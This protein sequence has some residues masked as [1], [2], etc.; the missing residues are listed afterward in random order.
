MGIFILTG[1]EGKVYDLPDNPIVF[2]SGE[3]NT[4]R[5]DEYITIEH[6]GKVYIMYGEIKSKGLFSDLSYA[7]GECL[8]YVGVDESDRIYALAGES[9][10]EW[11]IEYY[12]SGL[13]DPPPVVLREISAK[14][15]DNIPDCVEPFGYNY[16]K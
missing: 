12:Y 8:G 13:M 3:L 4:D 1:C 10:D 6:N 7:F 9:T 11:L 2:E 15:S 5:N 16:W 14:G